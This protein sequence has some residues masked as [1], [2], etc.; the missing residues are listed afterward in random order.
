MNKY[1]RP[2]IIER[3]QR[4]L[5]GDAVVD[6]HIGHFY[7]QEEKFLKEQDAKQKKV[8]D[9]LKS[10]GILSGDDKFSYVSG[11]PLITK[12]MSEEMKKL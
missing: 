1:P 2:G 6:Y 3:I 7:S 12:E 10:K 8:D 9:Y 5:Y 4:F 11:N